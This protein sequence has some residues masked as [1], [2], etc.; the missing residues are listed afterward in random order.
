MKHLQAGRER[1]AFCSRKTCCRGW[2]GGRLGF[3]WRHRAG[4]VAEELAH[5]YLCS[6]V[7]HVCQKQLGGIKVR[8]DSGQEHHT[9]PECNSAS[10]VSLQTWATGI[11]VSW[12][13]LSAPVLIAI[14]EQLVMRWAMRRT[15]CLW[16]MNPK[17]SAPA[18]AL[19]ARPIHS[20]PLQ[21]TRKSTEQLLRFVSSLVASKL[22]H[23]GV[24]TATDS[25][26][27][28]IDSPFFIEFCLKKK[29]KRTQQPAVKSMSITLKHAS[30]RTNLFLLPFFIFWIL[31]GG[32]H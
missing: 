32:L 22:Q 1:A 26:K 30:C 11:G 18:A 7:P 5:C 25:C 28:D 19:P 3:C 14:K 23:F 17:L 2:E 12:I 24:A 21:S 31:K 29:K 6:P 9:M 27:E 20:A 10:S 8:Q 13:C 4:E 15:R 16:L